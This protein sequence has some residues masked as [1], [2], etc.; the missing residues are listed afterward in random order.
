MSK[1]A[2]II[3]DISHEELDKTFQYIIPEELES[4]V[5]I[6][7]EV[8]IPFGKG[9]RLISG[10]VIG[11]TSRPAIDLD[12]MKAVE[13]VQ[14]K[15]FAIEG[16]LIMLAAWIKE[17][18]GST[19]IQA[20]KTV[21]PVKKQVRKRKTGEEAQPQSI[22][23]E[24]PLILNPEQQYISDSIVN[25]TEKPTAYLI[26][27]ITGSGKTEVYMD[28]I[29]RTVAAGRQAIV[30]IPE[31][32]L[33]FQTVN[34][35]QSRFGDRVS[36]MNSRL[37]AG[38]RYR[39]FQKAIN[40]ETD[41]MIGPRSALFTPFKNLGVIIIDEEHESSYKSDTVPR[42]HARDVA[43]ARAEMCGA[44]VVLGS[45]TPS[46]ESF[47]RAKQGEYKLF[48]LEKRA[49]GGTLANTHVVDMR[50][51]L[52]RGNKSIISGKLRE[53]MEERLR[54]SEQIMLFINRRGYESF[55]SCRSCGSPIKCPHCDV[56]LTQH[57]KD[58][59]VCHY[60]GYTEKF[61]KVCKVCGSPY[62]AGFKAGTEK[63]QE[64]VRSTFPGARIL[65][66]DAD[67]TGR[68]DA[69]ARILSAFSKKEADILIGTQ[70]IVKGHDYANVT[71]VGVLAAD[72]SLYSSNYLSSERTFQLL[73]QAAGRAGRGQLSGD[74]VIQTYSPDNYAV[75]TA[76]SQD[77]DRFYE[78]EI[79]YRK[80]LRYPPVYSMLLVLVSSAIEEDADAMSAAIASCAGAEEDI[81]VT[82]PAA[83]PI[84]KVK[85]MHKR[86]V[87]IK[88]RERSRLREIKD[89]L[90]I[91][92]KND[93]LS[94]NTGVVFDFNPLDF[95]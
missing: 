46:V 72:L 74:V 37:S 61:D 27:G 88:A 79:G 12:K 42:Y 76:A 38:E 3:I 11:I 6:G 75:V 94:K 81:L 29:S 10:Y 19:M 60:C 82:G 13:S 63:V 69:H 25:D 9:N 33:T 43:I 56:A 49:T 86:V 48:R 16:Q 89:K 91:M 22:V 90:E 5:S 70:M 80:L 55:V 83:G 4:Q 78:Q 35:F 45:A 95:L 30:L 39:G 73:T 23:A 92:V 18:C 58:R 21:L 1:Y 65:R 26:H 7:S 2:D 62:V 14:T 51:E 53:L 32:A 31:I 8:V 40:G 68:K 84:S 85:D 41:I 34:R 28:I 71:L 36:I 20:L 77:Y 64:I 93:L 87:Y 47:Y 50:Q 24:E 66:M 44:K 17:N 59:L 52:K 54:R 15:S 57:G 67:T